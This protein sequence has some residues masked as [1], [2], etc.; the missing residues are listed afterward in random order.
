MTEQEKQYFTSVIYELKDQ[1]VWMSDNMIL[2]NID[3]EI[4][5]HNS[6]TN[7]IKLA[8]EALLKLNR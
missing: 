8:D 7:A 3:L 4:M 1:I 6:E 2:E 5:L